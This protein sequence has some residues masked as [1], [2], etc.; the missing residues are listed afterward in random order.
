[1]GVCGCKCFI[2]GLSLID[3]IGGSFILLPRDFLKGCRERKRSKKLKV[4]NFDFDLWK[5]E[6]ELEVFKGF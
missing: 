6:V 5:W 3:K 1:M 4:I 2:G